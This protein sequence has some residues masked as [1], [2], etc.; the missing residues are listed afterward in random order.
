[1][2]GTKPFNE[3]VHLLFVKSV[4]DIFLLVFRYKG[5]PENGKEVWQL[6]QLTCYLDPRLKKAVDIEEPSPTST[7]QSIKHRLVTEMVALG[8]F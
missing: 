2:T 7:M 6:L 1:M 8:K 3:C 5:E 4:L